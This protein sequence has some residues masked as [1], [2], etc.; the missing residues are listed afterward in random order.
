M[1]DYTRLR[2][3][4]ETHKKQYPTGTRIYLERMNDQ[5]DPVPSGTRGTVHH[6]DD[7]DIQI[8]LGGTLL[9]CTMLHGRMCRCTN[10]EKPF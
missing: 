7:M 10:A 3:Q 6:V 4:A 1:N 2:M 8:K 5:Y 9:R